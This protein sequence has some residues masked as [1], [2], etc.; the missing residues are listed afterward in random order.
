MLQK[1]NF[2]ETVGLPDRLKARPFR[3]E[4]IR[5]FRRYDNLRPHDTRPQ[6]GKMST[7]TNFGE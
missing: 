2:S 1:H 6:M 3:G 5:A 4:V 7:P